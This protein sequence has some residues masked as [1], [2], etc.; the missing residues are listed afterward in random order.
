MAYLYRIIEFLFSKRNKNAAL[1]SRSLNGQG[2]PLFLLRLKDILPILTITWRLL[3]YRLSFIG[4]EEDMYARTVVKP[5]LK[6]VLLALKVF[7]S[8]MQFL[9]RLPLNYTIFI[10]PTRTLLTGF[11][12]PTPSFSF[13]LTVSFKFPD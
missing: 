6:L 13:T 11:L 1:S 2:F 12:F 8:L 9:I 5:F 7:T 3:A 4:G 10:L